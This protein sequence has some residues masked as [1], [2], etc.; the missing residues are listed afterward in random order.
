V[1]LSNRFGTAPFHIGS[2]H[3]AIPESRTSGTLALGTDKSLSF[4]GAADVTIPAGAEYISDPLTFDARPLSDLAITMHIDEPPA[5][6]TG[7]P[8]S[9]ET[10]FLVHGDMVSAAELPHAKTVDHWYF[11]SAVD[12]TAQPRARAVVTLG[13][14]ITD[15]HGATTNGNDRWPDV[16]AKRLQAQVSTRN[17]AVLN[18]GIGGNRLLLD[19]L[20][21]NALARFTDDVIAQTAAKYVI[22]LEGIN[23]IGTL[24]RD[25]DVPQG[26]H[27]A[28]VRHMIAAYEQMIARAHAH[29]IKVI[30]A[31]ILPFVGSGYYHPG[32]ASDA[33]RQAVNN[34]IRLPGHFDAVVDLDKVTRDPQHPDQLLAEYDSGD[35]LHPSPAG[36]AAMAAAIPLSLFKEGTPAAADERNSRLRSRTPGR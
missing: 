19:G 25:H 36:Y 11:I 3:V 31:T 8:G 29:G 7:H 17:V 1:H 5:Q 30:G 28:L 4:G 14:S 35:H 20:G 6:Q 27:D 34:W 21:P 16:L 26:E 2:V 33:D 23:D 32:H 24:A 13:D 9:R 18:H 15:G 10:S 22:V 12:V